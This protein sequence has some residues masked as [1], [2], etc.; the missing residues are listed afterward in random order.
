MRV[1]KIPAEIVEAKVLESLRN[2][3]VD[4]SPQGGMAAPTHRSR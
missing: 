3:K 1:A 2:R 4:K